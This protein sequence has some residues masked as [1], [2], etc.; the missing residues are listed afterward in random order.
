MLPGNY[1]Q[2]GQARADRAERFVKQAAGQKRSDDGESMDAR[3]TF[4]HIAVC[5]RFRDHAGDG[6]KQFSRDVVVPDAR[7]IRE[8]SRFRDDH[9]SDAGKLTIRQQI[10]GMFQKPR[11]CFGRGIVE[12]WV[13]VAERRHVRFQCRSRDRAEE[14]FFR[15]EVEVHGSLGDAGATRDV[16][17]TGRGESVLGEQS[18]R[19]LHDFGGPF[20][21]ATLAAMLPIGRGFHV[22]TAAGRPDGNVGTKHLC[23]VGSAP[24]RHLPGT[25]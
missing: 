5:L 13:S 11:D 24:S 2:V 25:Y 15:V 17:Q 14:L 10:G 21:F 7:E 8:G 23:I 6:A 19:R 16:I 20:R 9:P 22:G 4:A 18:C 3:I 1:V 12:A